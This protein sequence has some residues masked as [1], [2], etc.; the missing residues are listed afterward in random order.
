[1]AEEAEKS[2][3]RKKNKKMARSYSSL[4]RSIN[5]GGSDSNNATTLM[6][7][8]TTYLRE[9]ATQHGERQSVPA[10]PIQLANQMS[11]GNNDSQQH[12]SNNNEGQN[13]AKNAT[14]KQ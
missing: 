14:G 3:G 11:I 6:L 13:A 12:L 10:S 7:D 8:R 5:N 2:A 4:N 1:M 9:T